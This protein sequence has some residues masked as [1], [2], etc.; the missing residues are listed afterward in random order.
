M[1]EQNR[2]SDYLDHIRQAATDACNFVEG[3]EKG[4]VR[5]TMAFG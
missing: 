5:P 4:D 3:M 1:S 2:L